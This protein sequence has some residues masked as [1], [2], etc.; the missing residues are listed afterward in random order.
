M[1][2]QNLYYLH[3]LGEQLLEFPPIG[4]DIEDTEKEKTSALQQL[5]HVFNCWSSIAEKFADSSDVDNYEDVEAVAKRAYLLEVIQEALQD[6]LKKY[7]RPFTSL[8]Y[9]T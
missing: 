8:E 1:F 7:S 9:P 4:I 6:M 2:V 5:L 3:V